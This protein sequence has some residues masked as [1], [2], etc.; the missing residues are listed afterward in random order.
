MAVPEPVTVAMPVAVGAPVPVAVSVQ[1]KSGL[2]RCVILETK[3]LNNI[4]FRG[5]HRRA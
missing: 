5:G 4:Y 1:I 2:V 3:V